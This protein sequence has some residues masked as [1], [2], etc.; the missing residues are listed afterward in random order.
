MYTGMRTMLRMMLAIPIGIVCGLGILLI[1]WVIGGK[2]THDTV[3]LATLLQRWPRE[4]ILF[5]GFH[6]SLGAFIIRE[7]RGVR[8]IIAGLLA[9]SLFG[10]LLVMW[11]FRSPIDWVVF[12]YAQ[13]T[14]GAAGFAVLLAW[15]V[16]SIAGTISEGRY[17]LRDSWRLF[18]QHCTERLERFER[19]LLGE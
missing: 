2:S 12:P 15:L 14:Y 1:L 6:G 4:T 18:L 19:D 3:W 11:S 10:G 17:G 16:G 5:F 9:G 13:P 7:S 8:G